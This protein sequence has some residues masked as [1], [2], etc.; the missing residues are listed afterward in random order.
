MILQVV[1]DFRLQTSQDQKLHKE[2]M[3]YGY[4][5]NPPPRATYPPQK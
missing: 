1:G 5:T 2:N 4:S 3:F